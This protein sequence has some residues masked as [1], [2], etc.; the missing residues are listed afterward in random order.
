M[1]KFFIF[2]ITFVLFLSFS[3][4]NAQ[5]SFIDKITQEGLV[6]TPIFFETNQEAGSSVSSNFRIIN[7]TKESVLLKIDVLEIE[8]ENVIENSKFKEFIT[9]EF[10][11]FKLKEGEQKDINYT[12]NI[13]SD[14]KNG[15]YYPLIA[16]KL[17][18]T[19]PKSSGT[20]LTQMIA[21]QITL[22]VGGNNDKDNL[23][24]E[25]FKIKKG[26]VWTKTSNFDITIFNNSTINTTK[27]IIYFQIINPSQEIIYQKVLN[28]DLKSLKAQD[29]LQFLENYEFD[30]FDYKNI[31][32]F[33]AELLV[34]DSKTNFSVIEKIEFIVIPFP[35]LL[36]AALLFLI[37]LFIFFSILQR[38]RNK[39][40]VD[41][42]QTYK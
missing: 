5:D 4:V 38:R 14:I 32:K 11:E 41:Y 23:S 7:D 15:T 24:I 1:K 8:N 28:E 35:F 2:L 39:I 42:K 27:P 13:P 6:L 37:I 20:G 34:V 3:G 10:N 40:K 25:K 26:F 33:R 9:L 18:S 30:I 12:I 19:N 31:G 22:T 17:E 29:K 36:F 21:H 16:L